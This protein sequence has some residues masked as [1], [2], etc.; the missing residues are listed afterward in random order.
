[1]RVQAVF[2][3]N[4]SCIYSTAL[5]L[6]RVKEDEAAGVTLR[7]GSNSRIRDGDMC[8]MMSSVNCDGSDPF[9]DLKIRYERE[10]LN[11]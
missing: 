2:E 4:T 5:R 3:V 7:K 9:S 6:R 8:K 10:I 1:M 11:R